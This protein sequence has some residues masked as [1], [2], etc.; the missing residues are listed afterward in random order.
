MPA[1]VSVLL[2][3][4]VLYCLLDVA[5]S[6]PDAVRN[7]PKLMWVVLVILLPPIGGIVW[8]LAGRPVGRTAPGGGGATDPSSRRAPTPGGP[9]TP[10]GS[11]P[12]RR[13]PG[14]RGP[15]DDPDFLRDLDERLRRRGDEGGREGR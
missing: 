8:L 4:F 13:P 11:G 12:P 10:R 3:A 5:L 9:G 7:L 15:D 1:I 14:P 6:S 2:F